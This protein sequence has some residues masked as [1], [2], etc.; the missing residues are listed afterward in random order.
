MNGRILDSAAVAAVVVTFFAVAIFH[1]G[2]A[3]LLVA[4]FGAVALGYYNVYVRHDRKLVD[5][6]GGTG[7]PVN[8]AATLRPAW[9]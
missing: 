2:V 8:H 5:D 7:R 1:S 6:T 3:N 4:W 9:R